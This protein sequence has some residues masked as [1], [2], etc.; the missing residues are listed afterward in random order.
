MFYFRFYKKFEENRFT[1]NERAAQ[2]FDWIEK[3]DNHM[4]CSDSLFDVS[5]RRMV[6]FKNCEGNPG[7][8]WKTKGF[9]TILDLLM[10]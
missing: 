8:N 10:V 5:A 9:S 2:F 6:D 7:L 3:Y 1:S 4:Q